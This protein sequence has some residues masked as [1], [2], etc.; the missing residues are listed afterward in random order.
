MAKSGVLA[1]V[2]CSFAFFGDFECKRDLTSIDNRFPVFEF[3][4]DTASNTGWD[5][6]PPRNRCAGPAAPCD[7]RHFR[8]FAER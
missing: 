3:A 5:S 1:S 2:R 7:S 4:D 6:I 8:Q